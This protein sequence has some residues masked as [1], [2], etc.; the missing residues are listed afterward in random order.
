MVASNQQRGQ[1]DAHRLDS[2]LDRQARRDL[3]FDP[4]LPCGLDAGDAGA[5]FPHRNIVRREVTAIDQ[6]ARLKSLGSNGAGL[7]R[8]PRSNR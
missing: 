4:E 1:Q 7:R 5:Q 8:S 3:E 2:L 6:A